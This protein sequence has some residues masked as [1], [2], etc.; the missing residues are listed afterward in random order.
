MISIGNDIQLQNKNLIQSSESTSSQA[1][2]K[3]QNQSARR[4]TTVTV[5]G[6]STNANTSNLSGTSSVQS[7]TDLTND[8]PI[9]I[10]P[11]MNV[12]VN[13]S[14]NFFVKAQTSTTNY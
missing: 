8:L 3:I 11:N 9:Q 1:K 6:I 4:S 13:P 5:N 7:S 10:D 12:G 2:E 14:T